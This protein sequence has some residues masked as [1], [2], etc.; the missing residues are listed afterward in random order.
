MKINRNM[1]AVIANNQLLRTENKLSA[2]MERL[3]SGF[4]INSAED[5]PAGM[6][7]SNKMR[8]Q[9]DALDQAKDNS[10]DATSV[11]EIAD[12]ALNEVTSILQRMRELSVQAAT[13]SNTYEDKKAA[14]AEIDQLRQEVDRISTDTEYNTK[15]LLDGSSDTRVYTRKVD[16]ATGD[17]DLTYSAITRMNISDQV[18]TGNY[19]IEVAKDASLAEAMIYFPGP[20]VMADGSITI[21]GVTAKIEKGTSLEDYIATIHDVAEQ[22]GVSMEYVSGEVRFTANEYGSKNNIDIEISDELA[23]SFG[24]ITSG[25]GYSVSEKG[26]NVEINTV[27]G[28]KH[29]VVTT[30]GNRVHIVDD[31]GFKMDFSVDP[32]AENGVY[33]IDV[34]QIGSMTIQI[35]ANQYQ[36]MN[37]RIPEVSQESLYLDKIDVSVAGGAGNAITLLDEAISQ[38]SSIRSRIGAFQN[39][40]EYATNSLDETSENMTAAYSN[41]VD[42]DMAKEMTDYAAQNILNQAGIS[43]LSQANDMPQQV[44]S[45]LSR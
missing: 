28:F 8:A 32:E 10:T 12:G 36:E 16:D 5:N 44:L 24:Y 33:D 40:L 19:Q 26:T 30:D 27:D 35:G 20:D 41:L 21:N 9:I 29:P 11:M 23:K 15:V 22:A 42:A 4:K 43:V 34:T 7:I 2:T 37:V 14:Q 17:M 1:S 13:D 39:R 25:D 38:V 18:Q 3:S 45:L 31:N 6:A